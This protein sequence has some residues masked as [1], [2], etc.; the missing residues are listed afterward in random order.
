M[1][2]IERLP[3]TEGEEIAYVRRMPQDP[4]DDAVGV[5]WLGGFNSDMTG[6]KAAA[7]DDWACEDGRA[8]LRFDYFGHGASS[9]DFKDGTIGRWAD[10]AVAALDELTDGPQ[11]L[12]GSSMGGWI[13]LLAAL[14]RPEKV[15]GLVLIAPA[16][17]F[18]EDLMW[19][20]FSDEIKRQLQD[21]G[22][23]ERPSD[24]DPEPYVVTMDLIEEARKH[25]LLRAPIG[26]RVPIRILH[27]MQDPDVP[28]RRSLDLVDK[29]AADD[30]TVTFIKDGDHRLS[31]DQ[32]LARLIDTVESLC[33]EVD[34]PEDESDQEIAL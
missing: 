11:V 10:D 1:S 26:I 23:Y 30:V 15:A 6:T 27:G 28:W 24:Y 33:W 20:N 29:L 16:P 25:L 22:L 2:E 19:A 5:V 4:A 12:V 17:D 7:L 3:R 9:G 34:A 14:R 31:D 13:A 21:T 18:T 32:N 8:F